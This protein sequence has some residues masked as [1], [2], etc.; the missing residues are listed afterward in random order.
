[1]H[2]LFRKSVLMLAITSFLAMTTGLITKL[3]LSSQKDHQEHD[4]DRCSICKQL[5]TVQKGLPSQ[6]ESKIGYTDQFEHYN[7]PYYI[8]FVERPYFQTFSARPPPEAS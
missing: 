7:V 8:T 2:C 1:M 5:L 6:S 4:P 3:H